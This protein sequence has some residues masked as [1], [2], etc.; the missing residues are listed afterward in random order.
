MINQEIID[1]FILFEWLICTSESSVYYTKKFLSLS[2]NA[3]DF[4]LKGSTETIE[5]Y[6]TTNVG[7]NVSPVSADPK[8]DKDP[9]LC[10]IREGSQTVMYI[11]ETGGQKDPGWE[12][13]ADIE[14]ESKLK[15]NADIK[16]ASKAEKKAQNNVLSGNRWFLLISLKSGGWT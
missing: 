13:P 8:L 1:S 4:S 3:E 16:E 14:M 15:E 2:L 9:A 10:P 5:E 11:N 12:K 6:N 7:E